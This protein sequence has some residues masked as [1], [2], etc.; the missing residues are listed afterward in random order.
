MTTN[1][2]PDGIEISKFVDILMNPPRIAELR[3]PNV[4]RRG[5]VS[6]Y[7]DDPYYL[8][9]AAQTWSGKAPGVYV[10]LNHVNPDLL[11][12]SANK[13]EPFA[14]HTTGDADIIRRAWIPLDF[15]PVRP[16]GISSTDEEHQAALI[17]S[18]EC[19]QWL[20]DRGW[21]DPI[22]ADSGNGAHLL[23]PVDLPNEPD[24]TELIRQALVAL[25]NIFDDSV[26]KVDTSTYNASRIW[27]VY[28]TAVCKGSSLPDR[29]T[30]Y[31]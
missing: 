17:R 4:P 19:R 14:R 23:Y 3:I 13:A 21:P 1:I 28:G 15:D 8:L 16:A 18:Q 2:L 29:L 5:T 6:G 30:G 22:E 12:R 24:S 9:H 10:T 26:V 27:K 11:A 25:A 7:F 20:A 31:Q